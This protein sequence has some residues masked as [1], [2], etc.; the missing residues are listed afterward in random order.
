MTDIHACYVI[1]TN[2]KVRSLVYHVWYRLESSMPGSFRQSQR[3]RERERERESELE[4]KL[5]G[6]L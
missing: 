1:S 6:D 4:N 5:K 3:Y 2:S